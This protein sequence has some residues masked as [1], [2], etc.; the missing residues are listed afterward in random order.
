MLTTDSKGIVG[1]HS[2]D[3]REGTAKAGQ[4][5]AKSHQTR[6]SRD[7]KRNRKRMAV[8]ASVYHVPRYVRQPED[9]IADE[10]DLPPRPAIGDKR[11]WASVRQDAQSV[12]NSAFDEAIRRDPQQQRP[13]VVL[14]DGEAHQLNLIKTTAKQRSEDSCTAGQSRFR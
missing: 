12:I 2:E 6:L 10:P 3:L 8:V 14:V 4:K 7:E 1:M 13:W 11:V 9:M 5:A